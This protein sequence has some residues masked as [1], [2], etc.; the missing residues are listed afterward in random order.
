[1]GIGIDDDS[2]SA[3]DAGGYTVEEGASLQLIAERLGVSAES[4][5]EANGLDPAAEVQPGS[6]LVV[7]PH[8]DMGVGGVRD[9]F[10]TH[11]PTDGWLQ[12]TELAGGGHSPMPQIVSAGGTGFG[13]EIGD[14]AAVAEWIGGALDSVQ[15]GAVFRR[16]LET[17]MVL[18]SLNSRCLLL[19][20]P[21]RSRPV[22]WFQ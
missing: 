3:E 18:I 16:Q 10:E 17:E 21:L 8:T 14:Q 22:F 20:I 5:A 4:L 6:R 19:E 11:P 2:S 1:M 15:K 13:A 9:R 7:P 12:G